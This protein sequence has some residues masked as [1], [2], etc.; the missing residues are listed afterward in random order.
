M[1][2]KI[3]P[4]FFALTAIILVLGVFETGTRLIK[5]LQGDALKK[6]GE[7]TLAFQVEDLQPYVF[8][9]S[10]PSLELRPH[11]DFFFDFNGK[12]VKHEKK[13]GEY[14]IFIL[15]GSVAKGF[16]SSSPDKAYH[17]ILEAL[18]N[19]GAQRSE[20]RPYN[21]VSAG[22]LGYVSAQELILLQMG[23]L[24]F[25]P[26]LVIH[27]NGANDI[28]TVTQYQEPPGYPFYHQSL[29]RSLQ[30][31]KIN[32]AINQTITK[33][34]FLSELEAMFKKYRKS[35]PGV[36]TFNIDRHYR[37]NMT[38]SAQLLKANDIPGLIVLQ[39]LLLEKK[40]LAG[41]EVTSIKKLSQ[42]NRHI[43]L[44]TFNKLAVSLKEIS[45][46]TG[47]LWK[48]FQGVF[49]NQQE[50][51]FGDTIHLNDRGQ[52]LLAKALLPIVKDFLKSHKKMN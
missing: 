41:H 5:L 36:T 25:K 29:K 44:S 27:L 42:N 33:S 4:I 16:G 22:R 45:E 52:R 19:E 17:Q 38:Q 30:A 12:T 11:G 35:E 40:Q 32:K 14:R 26:D 39:P 50:E 28:L 20:G 18:L 6:V 3:K 37:R 51:T 9:R 31:V 13:N 21:V 46:K 49:D 34:A 24:E 43:W 10:L 15:G 47:I 23:I 7:K 2:Q 8:F 48:N 1:K